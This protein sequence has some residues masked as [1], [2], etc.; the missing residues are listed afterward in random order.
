MLSRYFSPTSPIINY[1][2]L[3]T[4]NSIFSIPNLL[5]FSKYNLSIINFKFRQNEKKKS[6]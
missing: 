4:D 5:L 1:F 3:L 2:E 6:F